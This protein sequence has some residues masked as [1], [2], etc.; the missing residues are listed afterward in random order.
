MMLEAAQRPIKV[1]EAPGCDYPPPMHMTE[2]DDRDCWCC[3]VYELI[4]DDDKPG[5]SVYVIVHR[6]F[7]N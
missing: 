6:S 3:P 2:E 7:E 5:T 1:I 4:E